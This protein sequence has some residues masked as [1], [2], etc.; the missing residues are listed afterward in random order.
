MLI[1]ADTNSERALTA[2]GQVRL[3]VA[4]KCNL[5]NEE[6]FSF[7]WV[8]EFPL[9]EK[10]EENDR[11]VAKHHPFTMPLED[12]IEKLETQPENMRARAYDMI[13]NGCEI[14]GGS[15]RINNPDLQQRMFDALGLD[16]DYAKESFGFLCEAYKYG[17]PPHGGMAFGFDRLCMLMCK[18]Q[19]IR[20][21][22]AF[23]K[24]Q[25]SGELMSDAPQKVDAKQLDELFITCK[26]PLSEDESKT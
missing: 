16:K 24:V 10:D 6:E 8:T 1:V 18:K 11:L 21:V 7:L 17:A 2:L 3:A 25:N 9:F 12:D 23:P 4:Q 20:D 19:S 13:L 5:I 26:E 22:I 15:I 14:G